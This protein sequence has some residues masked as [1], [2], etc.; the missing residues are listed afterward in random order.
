MHMHS[1]QFWPEDAHTINKPRKKK[2]K[3]PDY[4]TI[5]QPN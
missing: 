2:K 1:Y 4:M 5:N 3:V